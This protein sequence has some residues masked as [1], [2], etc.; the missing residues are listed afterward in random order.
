MSLSFPVLISTVPLW[1]IKYR[2]DGKHRLTRARVLRRRHLLQLPCPF[3]RC[4]PATRPTFALN[5]AGFEL[6][7][8]WT[9]TIRARGVQDPVGINERARDG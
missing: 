6:T 1:Q 9:S 4:A 3:L 8:T 5:L 7:A 2:P